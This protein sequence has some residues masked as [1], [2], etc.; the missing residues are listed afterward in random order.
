MLQT[1]VIEEC[2]KRGVAIDQGNLSKIERG[3]IKWPAPKVVAALADVLSL[4]TS[5]IYAEEDAA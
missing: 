5:E 4:E 3:V 2:A 1:D